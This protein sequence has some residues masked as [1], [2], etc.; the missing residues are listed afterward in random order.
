M[1]AQLMFLGPPSADATVA[2]DEVACVTQTESDAW[3]SPISAFYLV[4]ETLSGLRM[5]DF[6][7]PA[8]SAL[9]SDV[10]P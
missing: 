6:F 4:G 10:L 7:A 1:R 5:D 3:A 9:T 8:G 2:N